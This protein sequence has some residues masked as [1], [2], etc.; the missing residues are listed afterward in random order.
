M[1]KKEYY[2]KVDEKIIALNED[3][4]TLKQ[5]VQQLKS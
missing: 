1:K 4:T 5:E 3:V 2:S